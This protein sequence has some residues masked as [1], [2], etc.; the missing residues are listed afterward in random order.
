MSSEKLGCGAYLRTSNEIKRTDAVIFAG[1]NFEVGLHIDR[2][3]C[4]LEAGDNLANLTCA[5]KGEQPL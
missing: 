5:R 2:T 1:S 4:T 3:I